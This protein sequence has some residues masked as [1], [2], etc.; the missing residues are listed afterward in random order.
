MAYQT[1]A[2]RFHT[3]SLGN[4][5][6]CVFHCPEHKITQDLDQKITSY[7]LKQHHHQLLIENIPLATLESE[8]PKNDPNISI[9]YVVEH[10]ISPIL[11]TG[12]NDL[13]LMVVPKKDIS[14]EDDMVSLVLKKFMVVVLLVILFSWLLSKLSIEIGGEL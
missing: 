10:T 4:T 13:T 14:Y 3:L 5:V 12:N 11:H 6:V 1:V 2:I 8:S 7:V 9:L